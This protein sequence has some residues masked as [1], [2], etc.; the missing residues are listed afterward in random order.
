MTADLV[1]RLRGWLD[2]DVPIGV[3]MNEAAAEIE[4]L[5]GIVDG[6]SLDPEYIALT[7]ENSTLRAANDALKAQIESMIDNAS[8]AATLRAEVE[9]LTEA[10]WT[11]KK[12]TEPKTTTAVTPVHI[13][14]IYSIARYALS[15]AALAQEKQD[16]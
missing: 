9:R 2:E 1:T 7:N 13:P 3:I 4:R 6:F 5:A 16:E 8:K 12:M 14:S 11:I 15:R 10:L